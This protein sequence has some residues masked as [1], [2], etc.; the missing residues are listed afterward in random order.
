ML[1]NIL[2]NKTK[3]YL[4]I[5][6]SMVQY[7]IDPQERIHIPITYNVRTSLNIVHVWHISLCLE[8]HYLHRDYIN[9]GYHLYTWAKM[10]WTLSSNKS[11]NSL[12]IHDFITLSTRFIRITIIS[13]TCRLSQNKFPCWYVSIMFKENISNS[14]I[15]H[16]YNNLHHSMVCWTLYGIFE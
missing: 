16:E 11:H 2:H 1:C 13:Y 5:Y 9:M 14:W 8:I 12:K 4:Y 6:L 10:C 7:L 15:H 3:R